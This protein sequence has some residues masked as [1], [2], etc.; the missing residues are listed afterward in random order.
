M[1]PGSQEMTVL[2]CGFLYWKKSFS[3]NGK[4]SFEPLTILRPSYLF[5]TDLATVPPGSD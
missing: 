5:L 2:Y 3:L 4:S 1:H